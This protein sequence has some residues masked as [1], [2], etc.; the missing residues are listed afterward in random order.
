MAGLLY[1]HAKNV[2]K[3]EEMLYIPL[4]KEEIEDLSILDGDEKDSKGN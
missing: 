4:Y 2:Q 3:K 1:S